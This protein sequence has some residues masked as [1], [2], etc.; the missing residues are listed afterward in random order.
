MNFLF[1]NLS[2]CYL[3]SSIHGSNWT[4]GPLEKSKDLNKNMDSRNEFGQ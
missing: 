3:T 4:E 1:M 2:L